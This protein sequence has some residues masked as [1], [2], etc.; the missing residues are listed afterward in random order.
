LTWLVYEI[1]GSTDEKAL[2]YPW[3]AAI[4]I[5]KATVSDFQ[6]YGYNKKEEFYVDNSKPIILIDNNQKAIFFG[7]DKK[8][9]EIWFGRVKLGM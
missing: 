7:A 1:A 4:D 6:Q 9:K 2:I 3:V 5:G 8:N